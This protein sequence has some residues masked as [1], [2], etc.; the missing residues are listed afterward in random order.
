MFLFWFLFIYYHRLLKHLIQS[1]ILVQM[2]LYFSNSFSLSTRKNINLL[3]LSL[4]PCLTL[5]ILTFPL[6]L[7]NTKINGFITLSKYPIKYL[8]LRSQTFT[9]FFH[10]KIFL[11]LL[12]SCQIL[13]LLNYQ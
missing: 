10:H 8:R 1:S 2:V 6:I 7:D 9:G 11:L 13:T 3:V 12:F 4:S 5:N